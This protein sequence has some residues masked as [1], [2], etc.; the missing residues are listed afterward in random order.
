MNIE[1][2][3]HA[4]ALPFG[5][6]RSSREPWARPGGVEPDLAQLRQRHQDTLRALAGAVQRAERAEQLLRARLLART[7]PAL[8]GGLTGGFAAVVALRLAGL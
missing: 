2:A 4:A 8:L 5:N 1:D 7:W 3:M 6:Q